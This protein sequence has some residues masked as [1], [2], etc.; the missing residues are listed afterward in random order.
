MSD[1]F[2]G[3]IDRRGGFLDYLVVILIT[4]ILIIFVV[5]ANFTKLDLVTTG[6]G[7]L[8]ASGQNKNVQS[9]VMGTISGFFVDEGSFVSAGE[10]IAT[11]N[12]TDA[13]SRL[14]ELEAK[15]ENKSIRLKRLDI[16]L[17]KK[18]PNVLRSILENEEPNLVEAEISLLISRVSSIQAQIETWNKKREGQEKEIVGLDAQ[19]LGKEQLL[20][21]VEAELGEILPL[22]AIGTV[23]KSDRFKLDRD[24]TS[25]LSEMN[26]L[27]E[28]K[29]NLR[30]GIEGINKEIASVVKKYE[31]DILQERATVIGE[32]TEL[33][34]RLPAIQERLRETEIKS[35]IQGQVN[36]AFYNT[37]GAVV[38]AGE[39]LAEIVPSGDNLLI[40]A[41]INPSDIATVEPGQDARIAL[42]AYDAARYGYLYGSVMKVSPD[43][44]F[45][46][47]TKDYSYTVTININK[48]IFEDDGSE[49]EIVPGM[50]SQ[51]DI[52]RG[53][54]TILEYMWQPFAKV[55]DTAFR[56]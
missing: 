9:P 46:D 29:D 26:V 34:A 48:T 5:W 20:E 38:N 55:K 2:S 8:I 56:E 53:S 17:Q 43:T 23:S 11:I 36:V 24:K 21:L 22:I 15:I 31:T 30:I 32:L 25:L 51:V 16:E 1:K 54:R 28:S 41:F 10:L 49:V 6:S 40:E 13:L 14:E 18:G 19:L 52:I 47:E 33:T 37:V 7:R 44:V 50:M 42:T 45:R 39:I 12:P 4:I 27:T 35:P 3:D